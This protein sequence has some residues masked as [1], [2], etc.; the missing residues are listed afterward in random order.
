MKAW[1][2]FGKMA[3]SAVAEL[4]GFKLKGRGCM[5][6]PIGPRARLD[7]H[8]GRS[9]EFKGHGLCSL[10]KA[11]PSR[12]AGNFRRRQL[13][14]VDDARKADSPSGG[15]HMRILSQKG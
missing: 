11:I 12:G 3:M 6:A 8:V 7:E 14:T 2:I 1:R 15:S 5:M 9:P 13:K 10:A 4:R